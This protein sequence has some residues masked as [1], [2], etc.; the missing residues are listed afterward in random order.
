MRAAN[1]FEIRTRRVFAGRN[2]PSVALHLSEL[3]HHLTHILLNIGFVTSLLSWPAAR[4]RKVFSALPGTRA[5][6]T[7]GLN[8]DRIHNWPF[9]INIAD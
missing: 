8:F 3:C 9:A 2:R 4:S 6:A 1:A 7:G 5:F